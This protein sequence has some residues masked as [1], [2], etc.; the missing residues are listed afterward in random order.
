MVVDDNDMKQGI[1]KLK[2]DG[3]ENEEHEGMDVNSIRAHE[4]LTK[5]K[6]INFIKIGK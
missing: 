2:E 4:E 1:D 3:K 6:T 5:F